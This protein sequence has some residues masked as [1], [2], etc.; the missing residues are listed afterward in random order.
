MPGARVPDLEPQ[1]P[2]A[3]SRAH[4]HLAPVRI[5]DGVGDEVLQNSLQIAR[6]ARD[7]GIAGNNPQLHTGGS[8]R[9]KT[10]DGDGGLR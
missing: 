10:D 2:A 6:V 5:T 4:E 7:H 9:G 3:P 1:G 8:G